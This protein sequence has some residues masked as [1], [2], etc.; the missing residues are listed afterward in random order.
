MDDYVTK[1]VSSAALARVLAIWGDAG[2]P[3]VAPDEPRVEALAG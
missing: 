3:A 1:P 2:E